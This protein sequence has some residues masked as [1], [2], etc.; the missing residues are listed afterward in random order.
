MR[1]GAGMRG[2]C[3]SS[4]VAKCTRFGG[5]TAVG[6]DVPRR[7]AAL[8]VQGP[9]ATIRSP[10]SDWLI[11][12]L[13]PAAFAWTRLCYR[14]ELEGLENVPA[15]GAVVLTPNHV[16]YL[17]PIWASVAIERRIYYMAWDAIFRIPILSSLVRACG[18]FP[19]RLQGHDKAAMR[20]AR[21]HLAAGRA[22]MVFPE[23]GR[24]TTHQLMPFKAGA[25]RLALVAGV[26]VVPVSIDG[27]F[28][29]WPPGTVFPKLFGRIR[30]VYHPAIP[31]E[32][33]PEN[34]D[35]AELRHRARELADEAHDAVARS[36]DPS[37]VPKRAHA[38]LRDTEV[39]A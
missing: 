15:N 1:H 6:A 23:G 22:L 32:K 33:A 11:R 30:I 26:P 18:A 21:C 34:A 8:H 12:I 4:E 27:G 7:R 29:I 24:T 39:N 13:R 28:D 2:V 16:T 36:L 20:E 25:F 10:M 3:R 38:E 17:D 19:V 35:F 31:V 37:R 9:V 14:V 5:E